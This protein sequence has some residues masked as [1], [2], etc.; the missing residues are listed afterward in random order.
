MNYVMLE[1][2]QPLH[3]FDADKVENIIVR[4]AKKGES[5][6]SI[7]GT[8]YKLT[9]EMLVIAD[10]KRALAIAG[11]KGGKGSEVTLKTKRIIVESA[12]FDS[13]S[14]YKT[15]KVLNLITDASIRFSHG[16]HP[17]LAVMGLDRAAGLLKEITRAKVGERSDS[18]TKPLPRHVLKFDIQEFNRF[19][20]MEMEGK[21]AADYLERLGFKKLQGGKWEVPTLRSDIKNHQD[22]V[23][24]VVRLFG[25]NKLKP[26]APHVTLQPSESD[27]ALLFKDKIR[28][29]LSGFGLNEVYNHSFMSEKDARKFVFD[30]EIIELENPI[31]GEFQHLRPSLIPNFLKNINHNSKFFNEVRI[32]EIGRIFIKAERKLSELDIL[33]IALAS[34]K[35]ETFFELKGLIDQ[36]LKALG[37]V[38]FVMVKPQ[39]DN[40]IRDFTKNYIEKNTLLEIKSGGN[41]GF[42][43]LGQAQGKFKDWKVSLFEVD[44]GQILQLVREEKEYE[45]LSKYPSVMRDISLLVNVSVRIGD[46]IQEIQRINL[47]LIRDVD[48]VDEYRDAKWDTR[49]SITLRIVFQSEERTLTNKEVDREMKKVVSVLENKFG[50]RVR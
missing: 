22:L 45:P 10:S 44:V 50:A 6:V 48:L 39:K 34:K 31:S 11:V 26:R 3:A 14:I 28:K 21:T 20:G 8:R 9:P 35:G 47:H 7:D 23:E 30:N 4:R 25:Y 29:I 42:A 43:Y 13:V 27:E 38:D 40:W 17:E 24:E 46:L 2:G 37:L 1:V 36:L 15:S 5:V 16:L 49:Q 41:T 19:I 12:N 32:F 18:L 33:G